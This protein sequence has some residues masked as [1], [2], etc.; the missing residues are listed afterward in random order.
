MKIMSF[1]TLT[2]DARKIREEVFVQE[3]GFQ[4][5]I[6]QTDNVARHFVMY[7]GKEPI[8]VCRVYESERKGE[9]ILGRLAVAK[10]Y[11]GKNYG[12]EMVRAAVSFVT[13]NGGNTLSLHA[14]CRVKEFYSSLGFH[15]YGVVEEEEGCPHIW[16]KKQLRNKCNGKG[17]KCLDEGTG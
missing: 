6:D 17:G 1:D 14:Q 2:Q 5:E 15:E 11:R 13:A 4:N 3:Q 10:Q 7:D 12:S 16:M 9:F 8:A